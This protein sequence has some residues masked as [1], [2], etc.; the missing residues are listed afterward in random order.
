M[1][2]PRLE[3]DLLGD[4]LHVAD[5]LVDLVQLLVTSVEVSYF[6]PEISIRQFRVAEYSPQLLDTP[7][8]KYF[9]LMTNF[10]IMNRPKP[11]C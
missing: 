7:N 6:M 1:D 3:V 5:S 2:S 9:D 10:K 8:N 4:L 11:F